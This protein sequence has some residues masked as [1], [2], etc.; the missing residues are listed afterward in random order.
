V[1]PVLIPGWCQVSLRYQY[2]NFSFIL[3]VCEDSGETLEGQAA[4][5]RPGVNVEPTIYTR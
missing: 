4:V 1:D 5:L 3:T 2:G